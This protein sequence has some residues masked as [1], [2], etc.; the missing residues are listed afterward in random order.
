LI[1]FTIPHYPISFSKYSIY[2]DYCGD[3]GVRRR[4]TQIV[5]ANVPGELRNESHRAEVITALDLVAASSC[6]AC[7]PGL[8]RERSGEEESELVTAS[9]EEPAGS[10]FF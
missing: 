2:L 10:G 6:R 1:V 3:A 4:D 7:A 9:I 8:G 5:V